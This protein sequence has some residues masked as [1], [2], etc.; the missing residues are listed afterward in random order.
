VKQFINSMKNFSRI[1]DPAEIDMTPLKFPI[2]V[3]GPQLFHREK[4]AYHI[5]TLTNKKSWGILDFIF[6]LCFR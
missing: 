3:L 5:L 4:S 1:I 2:V 6:G